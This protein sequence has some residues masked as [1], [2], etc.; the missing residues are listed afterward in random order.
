[1]FG[2]FAAAGVESRD[3]TLMIISPVH[4]NLQEFIG[5]HITCQEKAPFLGKDSKN[6][7]RIGLSLRLPIKS[8]DMITGRWEERWERKASKKV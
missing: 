7:N 8:I 4:F 6:A 2:L 5:V 1:L 3:S